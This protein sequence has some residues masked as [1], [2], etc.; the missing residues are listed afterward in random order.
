M[1]YKTITPF[2]SSKTYPLSAVAIA[3]AATHPR[4]NPVF[5]TCA[6]YLAKMN[7]SGIGYV[8]YTRDLLAQTLKRSS[9]IRSAE[10][11]Q[12]GLSDG[13]A[14]Y[15]AHSDDGT[16]IYAGSTGN[17]RARIFQHLTEKSDTVNSHQLFKGDVLGLMVIQLPTEKDAKNLEQFIN[18]IIDYDY[19]INMNKV[20]T[21]SEEQKEQH[22]AYNNQRSPFRIE[23]R[24]MSLN[25]AKQAIFHKRASCLQMTFDSAK[26]G[27]AASKLTELG[28]AE[29]LLN[30][31]N[32]LLSK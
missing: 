5:K 29:R 15:I 22:R 25:A 3:S 12:V 7:I 10:A 30:A 24:P 8:T 14:V 20:D 4:V 16:K 19:L 13:P 11:D 23:G 21:K 32:E 27:M 18:T 6:S 1:N 26:A 17:V 28:W 31:Q 2:P 9:G